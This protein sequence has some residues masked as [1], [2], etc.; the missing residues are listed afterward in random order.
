MPT[1]INTRLEFPN[2]IDLKEFSLNDVIKNE[3][4]LNDQTIDDYKQRLA[5]PDQ[6]DLED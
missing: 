3:N 5:N 4:K 1:K 2:T 6:D